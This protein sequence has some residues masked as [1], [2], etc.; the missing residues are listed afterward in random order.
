MCLTVE[1][2]SSSGE[3]VPRQCAII[4]EPE[5]ACFFPTERSSTNIPTIRARSAE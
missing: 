4:E 3:S 2:V 1:A 5:L